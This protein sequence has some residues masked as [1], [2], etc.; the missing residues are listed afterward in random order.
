MILLNGRIVHTWQHEVASPCTVKTRVVAM[1][2]MYVRLLL[3]HDYQFTLFHRG[4]PLEAILRLA[5]RYMVKE[6]ALLLCVCVCV[7]V[8]GRKTKEKKV[9]CWYFFFLGRFSC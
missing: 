8:K 4:N 2:V 5:S 6:E 1:S 3:Q 7:C 9:W